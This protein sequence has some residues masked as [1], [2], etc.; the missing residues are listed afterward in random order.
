[1]H[2]IAIEAH[3]A[4][5]I[6]AGGLASAH[7]HALDD[8]ARLDV[9]AGDGLFDACDDDITQ[10]R[11]PAPGSAE[12]LDAHAL[13]GAGVV[14]HVDIGIHLN[15]NAPLQDPRICRPWPCTLFTL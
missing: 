8:I 6:A 5:V 9:A 12:H 15:H 3:I 4:A 1:H 13:L 11:I 2:R 14:G 7:D 10:T